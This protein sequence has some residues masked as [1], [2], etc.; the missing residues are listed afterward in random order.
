MVPMIVAESHVEE[1]ELVDPAWHSNIVSVEVVHCVQP[2]KLGRIH[3]IGVRVGQAA[4]MARARFHYDGCR[5]CAALVFGDHAINGLTGGTLAAKGSS[6]YTA[7]G[8]VTRCRTV[9]LVGVA[10]LEHDVTIS[11]VAR[12]RVGG[13]AIVGGGTRACGGKMQQQ[14]KSHRAQRR[15][16]A[17]L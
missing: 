10:R 6:D 2:V 16:N 8:A 1:S 9:R 15:L 4:W 3:N 14:G 5:P 13:R 11:N 12:V 7:P 17:H